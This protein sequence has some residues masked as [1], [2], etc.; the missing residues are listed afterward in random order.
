[1]ETNKDIIAPSI[2]H[3]Q[4]QNQWGIIRNELILS[5]KTYALECT[6]SKRTCKK[7]FEQLS[8]FNSAVDLSR[9]DD[10]T[11]DVK[12]DEYFEEGREPEDL[13]NDD[14]QTNQGFEQCYIIL[15]GKIYTENVELL[16]QLGYTVTFEVLGNEKPLAEKSHLVSVIC[17]G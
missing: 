3:E 12:I 4:I 13:P 11:L 1:M 6:L 7:T 9:T 8:K 2:T 10:A 14:L 17:W 15:D 5:L 16:Q